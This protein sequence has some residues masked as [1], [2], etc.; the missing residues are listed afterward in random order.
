MLLRSVLGEVRRVCTGHLLSAPG[1]RVLDAPGGD[2]V[3]VPDPVE[4]T[5]T[6]REENELG[7]LAGHMREIL[8][9]YRHGDEALA[10][11]GEPGP[12]Y[13]PGVP[14]LERY[15]ARGLSLESI[16]AESGIPSADLAAGAKAAGIPMRVGRHRHD[17]CCGP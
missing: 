13:A 15:Q 7:I 17:H 9:G 12:E 1:T 16:A 10:L 8:T 6:G 4:G 5:L 14:K 11:P 2:L 3:S